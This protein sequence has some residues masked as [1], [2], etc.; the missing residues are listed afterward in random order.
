[1]P[2]VYGGLERKRFIIETNGAGVGFVDVDDDGWLDALV[3]NGTRLEDGTRAAATLA[4]GRGADQPPLPQQRD[5]T[6][7]G[8]D[9]AARAS[10][11]TGWASASA[12]ATTTTTAGSTCS[13]PTTAGTCSI[14]TAAAAAS[15][16]ST[17]S[18]RPRR[19]PRLAGARAARSSTTTATAGSIC[20][21]PTTSRFDLA[22]APEPGAGRQLPLEGRAGQLR[23]R[24]ACRPTRTCSIATRATAR[25]TDVSERLGHRARHRALLDDRGRGRPRRRRLDRHL[26][27]LR[28]DRRRSSTATT[29]TA[30][31]PTSRSRAARAYSELGDAAGRA[32]G[33]ALGDFDARRPARPPQDPLRRRHPG[34]LPQ[35]RPGPVRGRRGR[36]RA[37][38]CRTATCSGARACPTSTTT[39]GR[40]S[41]YVTGNVYP[42]IERAL[43]QYPHRSPRIVF[44]N[45]AA[46]RFE[47]V[48]ARERRRARRRRT[49]AA[50]PR[51]A[52]STTTATSTCSS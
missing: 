33:S 13:S 32:W 3:L 42:E 44:R 10:T 1:M 14:A 6:L 8:R 12:P 15:R 16:T 52:T 40:T 47:D 30:P 34:A 29:A 22:T 24:R 35:P 23:A 26:R 45:R 25:F 4:A 41:F 2:S 49:R 20:S 37:S 28:L 48:S 38:A 27:G 39:A 18:G 11:R 31:S 21:S 50:A 43:P 17:A 36:R 7:R 5:G 9:R 51:S 46:G 19:R